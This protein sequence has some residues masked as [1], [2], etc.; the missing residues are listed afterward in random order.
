LWS[1]STGRV[2]DRPAFHRKPVIGL[3]LSPDGERLYSADTGGEIHVWDLRTFL[4]IRLPGELSRPGAVD[5]LRERL[6]AAA[7]SAEEKK[8]LNFSIE[9]ARWRQ[10]FDIELADMNAIS[11]GEFDIEI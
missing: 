1:L 11:V 5:E 7:L 4:T 8:W 3:A 10:R 9:L 2:I 6:K